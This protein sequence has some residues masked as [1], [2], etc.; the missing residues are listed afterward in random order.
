LRA[1]N[2]VLLIPLL[3]IALTL[4]TIA[5]CECKTMKTRILKTFVLLSIIG[6]I[7]GL[8]LFFGFLRFNYPKTSKFPIR[9]IDISHYQGN[10][11]WNMLKEENIQFVY[12][13][14]TEGS[15]F[16]DDKFTE[17][18]INALKN[19]YIVGAYHFYVA[20]SSGLEQADNFIKNVPKDSN[21]LPPVIDLE[22]KNVCNTNK[23]KSQ[24][25]SEIGDYIKTISIHYGQEPI[26]YTTYEFYKEYFGGNLKSDRIWIRDIFCYPKLAEEHWVIWQY[27]NRGRLKGIN[28]YVDLN[29][30]K[31]TLI[32]THKNGG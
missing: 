13:K 24:I 7:F 11:D 15:D 23:T 28:S 16:I 21:S 19:N 18:W 20:C 5:N 27:S 14:A 29:V 31:N 3:G 9:G 17:N 30:M 25:I 1:E 22:F 10:I 2:F 6:L 4:A 8:L 26:I 12:I 32:K